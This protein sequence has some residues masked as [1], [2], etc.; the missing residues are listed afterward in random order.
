MTGVGVGGLSVKSHSQSDCLSRPGFT[1]PDT[2]SIRPGVG[3]PVPPSLSACP[4]PG[5]HSVWSPYVQTIY[6]L[7]LGSILVNFIMNLPALEE[8]QVNHTRR[9]NRERR[10]IFGGQFHQGKFYPSDEKGAVE[11]PGFRRGCRSGITH[12]LAFSVCLGKR[13]HFLEDQIFSLQSPCILLRS[14]QRPHPCCTYSCH[15]QHLLL[16]VSMSLGHSQHHLCLLLARGHVA[17]SRWVSFC[18]LI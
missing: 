12:L 7:S 16:E 5:L 18:F 15:P 1:C 2:S 11:P 10:D 8:G 14:E 13:G 3:C 4:C 9:M 17:L 6:L